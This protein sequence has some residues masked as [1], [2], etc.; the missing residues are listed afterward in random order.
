MCNR[1]FGAAALTLTLFA[2]SQALAKDDVERAQ[3]D[4]KVVSIAGDK[5]VMSDRDNG[6][7]HSHA[8]SADTKVCIDGKPAKIDNLKAGMWIR[9]TM[10]S[11]VKN[12]TARIEALEKNKEFALTQIGK[13]V[14][15]TEDKLIMTN[16]DGKEV[17][18]SLARDG[19][20]TIDGKDARF[21][22]LKPGTRIRVTVLGDGKQLVNRV[23]AI[24]NNDDFEK[25]G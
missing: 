4:G 22:D 19:T 23:E 1:M 7:E 24:V 10:K 14:S 25:L 17:T 16:K 18:S 6:K 21:T 2:G 11:D 5:L 20:L 3:H 12:A 13:V 8:L 9:V 15:I